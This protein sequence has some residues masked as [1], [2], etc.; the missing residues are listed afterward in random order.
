MLYATARYARSKFESTCRSEGK[1]AGEERREEFVRKC[2]CE[3]K[4]LRY[5][6]DYPWPMV[7]ESE[8]NLRD[9][10]VIVTK[11]KTCLWLSLVWMKEVMKRSFKEVTSIWGQWDK[12]EKP[13]SLYV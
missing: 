13:F 12:P 11:A 7:S 8:V 6:V 3:L 9:G 1:H 4:K 2:V 10:C 5:F